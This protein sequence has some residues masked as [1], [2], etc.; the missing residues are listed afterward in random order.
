MP[1]MTAEQLRITFV[2][3]AYGGSDAAGSFYSL[4]MLALG[5]DNGLES[6]SLSHPDLIARSS[7]GIKRVPIALAPSG[8]RGLR[9]R[10][11]TLADIPVAVRESLAHVREF[12]PHAIYSSQLRKDVTLA[13]L[14]SRAAGLP[15]LVHLHYPFGPW[16]GRP[17]VH[18]I[19]RAHHVFAV[20]EF[21]RQTALLRGFPS[22]RISTVPNLTHQEP[23]RRA[24]RKAVRAQLGV[25]D[26]ELIV[27]AVGRLDPGK[28]FEHLI[29]AMAAIPPLD[30][31]VHVLICG[32]SLHLPGFDRELEDLARSERVDDV[33]RFLGQRSDVA[34]LLA[35]ADVFCLPTEGEAFG[36]VFIEAMRAG[37]PVVALRSG[38]VPEI[39]VDGVTGWLSY[40]GDQEALTANLHRML[41]DEEERRAFGEAGRARLASHFDNATIAAQWL[42]KMNR[43][44]G[45]AEDPGDAARPAV[46]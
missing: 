39:V 28:G 5:R 12:E 42:R 11:A 38:G 7:D 9:H 21:T 8:G 19:R 10:L 25:G 16:L 45:R 27:I 35:A 34:D 18:F 31:P 37:L 46:S 32:E 6:T 41:D 43:V 3:V 23:P 24:D 14:I 29:R 17:Q 15:H 44:L 20:S 33:V 4:L 30:R 13:H 36:L 22:D 26:N 1:R 2:E 40:P